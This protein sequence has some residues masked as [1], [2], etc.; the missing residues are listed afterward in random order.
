MTFEVHRDGKWP[1]GEKPVETQLDEEESEAEDFINR[2]STNIAFLEKYNN[3]WLSILKELKDDTKVT[4][5]HE[6]AHI[7]E[8]E[9]G[10]IEALLTGNKLLAGLKTNSMKKRSDCIT[11]DANSNTRNFIAADSISST[12]Q[13]CEC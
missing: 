6:Y 9:D 1:H 2:I 3:D 4:K 8:S 12:S 13:K 11:S 5:E 7:Y 10:L